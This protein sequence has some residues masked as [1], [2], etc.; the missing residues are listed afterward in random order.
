MK[1]LKIAAASAREQGME[2]RPELCRFK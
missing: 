1:I 2:F